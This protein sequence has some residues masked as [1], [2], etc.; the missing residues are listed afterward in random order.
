MGLLN[1]VASQLNVM[2]VKY[3]SK[4][5]DKQSIAET[6][7]K[8]IYCYNSYMNFK[9][10]FRLRKGILHVLIAIIFAKKTLPIIGMFM[11]N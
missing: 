4:V 7:K 6:D 3:S 5:N 8:S 11:C 1:M 2:A 10:S 9:K